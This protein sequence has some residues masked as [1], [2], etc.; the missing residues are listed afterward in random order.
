MEEDYQYQDDLEE[1]GDKYPFMRIQQETRDAI[2][3]MELK[4]IKMKNE[5]KRD[6]KFMD[7]RTFGFKK[8][9]LTHVRE[10][11][12]E[13]ENMEDKMSEMQELIGD[14]MQKQLELKMEMVKELVELKVEV[15]KIKKN[16]DGRST[17]VDT[18]VDLN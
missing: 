18:E 1:E 17:E 3:P 6:M 14:L 5:L 13:N 2:R 9:F 12:K 10:S 7:E 8:E 16:E 4:L 15:I 11:K